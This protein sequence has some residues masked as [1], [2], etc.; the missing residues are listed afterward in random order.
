MTI[1]MNN[2]KFIKNDLL[3]TGIY[4]WRIESNETVF[5]DKVIVN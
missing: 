5:S 1:T 4:I 3:D 2:T